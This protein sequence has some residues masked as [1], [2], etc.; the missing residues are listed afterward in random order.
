[1]RQL[2]KKTFESG[3][4]VH[5]S[6]FKIWISVWAFK[7]KYRKVESSRPVYY[8]ILDP[9]GQTSQYISIKFLIHKQ[10]ENMKM[11]YYSR[12]R[13]KRTPMLINFLT[14]FQGLRPYSRLHR[15]YLN[16]MII[17]YKGSYAYRK[18]AS[19]ST[20]Y[21]SENQIFYSLE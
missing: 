12:V 17:R 7:L 15:A 11:C 8:S 1:M 20:C 16:S 4:G 2:F 21:Y 3:N 19:R 10:S 18:V 6:P 13:N 9:L 5:L 14:F